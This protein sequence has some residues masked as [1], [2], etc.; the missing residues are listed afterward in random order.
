[1]LLEIQNRGQLAAGIT[2]YR[3]GHPQLI[4][5]YKNVGTVTEVFHLNQQADTIALMDKY[6]GVA[7]ISH[8]RYATCGAY[9]H[10]NAQSFDRHHIEKHKWFA[11]GFNGQLANF[12]E[13]RQ[14]ILSQPNF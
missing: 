2:V 8:L 9:D 13:L 11:F 6:A 12:P 4:D 7:A 14:E 1:L 5:T 10:L 3:P